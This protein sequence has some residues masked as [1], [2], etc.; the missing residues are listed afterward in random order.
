MDTKTVTIPNISCGH[1]KNRVEKT[2]NGVEGVSSAE[3][4]VDTKVLAL[5]W[6]ESKVSWAD[7]Q[8]SL[9]KIGYPP[10]A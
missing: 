3:V 4:T 1:C 9:E 8:G 5:A 7:L 10:E 6:D 2:M